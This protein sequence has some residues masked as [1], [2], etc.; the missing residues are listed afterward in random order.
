MNAPPSEDSD[1]FVQAWLQARESERKFDPGIL[2]LIKKHLA[3][4]GLQETR[5]LNDLVANAKRAGDSDG[6]D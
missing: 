1:D 6:S 2:A 5:L 3:R 4:D